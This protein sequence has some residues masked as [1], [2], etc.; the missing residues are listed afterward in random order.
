MSI[1]EFVAN[2]DL[3]QLAHCA[4]EVETRLRTLKEGEKVRLWQ[5]DVDRVICFSSPEPQ[6]AMEWLQS[7]LSHRIASGKLDRISVHPFSVYP[8]E[9]AGWMEVNDKPE[10]V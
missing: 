7:F 9:V 6:E 8:S 5:V 10:D 2:L 3:D 4:E 1:K